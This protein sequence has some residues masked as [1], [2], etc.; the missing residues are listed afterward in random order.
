MRVKSAES[1]TILIFLIILKTLNLNIKLYLKIQEEKVLIEFLLLVV[2]D[3][4]R[5]KGVLGKRH[6]YNGIIQNFFKLDKAPEDE[7]KDFNE[8]NNKYSWLNQNI[9]KDKNPHNLWA[10]FKTLLANIS[11]DQNISNAKKHKYS[12]ISLSQ[13]LFY[14]LLLSLKKRSVFLILF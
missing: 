8:M 12:K 13:I 4:K 5:L 14:V 9:R 6:S 2:V 3:T 1:S 11:K 10:L 7:S